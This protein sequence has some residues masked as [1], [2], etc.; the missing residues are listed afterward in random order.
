MRDGRHEPLPPAH[1]LRLTARP[2]H[3]LGAAA[4][5]LGRPG[6]RW[7]WRSRPVCWACMRWWRPGCWRW[8]WPRPSPRATACAPRTRRL[9]PGAVRGADRRRARWCDA[10]R[11]PAGAAAGAVRLGR[12][13]GAGLGRGAQRAP[14][15][16]GAA[17]AADRRRQPG[18]AVR[19]PGARRSGRCARRWR[20]GSAV[21]VV[22]AAVALAL[23]QI[24]RPRR[25][26]RQPLPRRPVRLLAA[27]L[28]GRR[29]ARRAAV[30]DAAGR[31]WRCCR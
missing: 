20:C 17:G 24:A 7:R 2:R 3:R 14:G 28:A 29:L 30:A 15:P 21:L 8:A 9:A 4:G 13:D 6:R 18:R 5:R 31:A 11:R 10:R 22:L 23:L 16:A 27:G 26:C 25:R 1:A 19:R 12:P